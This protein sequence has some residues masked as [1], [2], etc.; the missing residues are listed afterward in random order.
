MVDETPWSHEPRWPRGTPSGPT[1]PGAGRW[2]DDSPGAPSSVPGPNWADRLAQR[3]ASGVPTP[4][5]PQAAAGYRYESG[6]GPHDEAI[7][8][9]LHEHPD[10][11][12]AAAGG[13]GD[14][15]LD[16]ALQPSSGPMVVYRGADRSWLEPGGRQAT[17]FTE[18]RYQATTS[19]L[20]VAHAYAAGH[21][22]PAILE[23]HIHEGVGSA[24]IGGDPGI[25][26]GD[27]V[28]WGDLE[29]HGEV[30]LQRGVILRRRAGAV[31][32]VRGIPIIG[33]D[34]T[35]AP[36]SQARTPERRAAQQRQRRASAASLPVGTRVRLP[37]GG[38]GEVSGHAG[39]LVQVRSGAN[40]LNLPANLLER[41]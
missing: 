11:N 24:A 12:D 9:W 34:V 36:Q 8:R 28:D 20:G 26:P 19:S 37:S 17:S 39:G 16:A 14:D 29:A 35:L 3:V 4:S 30:L 18:P 21:D 23:M 1:G 22:R 32:R 31:R 33:V 15:A 10:I 13:A 27:E 7:G 5:S 40:T 25:Q 6:H 38:E 41:L 2:R